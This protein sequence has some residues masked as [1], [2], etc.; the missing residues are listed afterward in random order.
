MKVG[1]AVRVVRSIGT[2]YLKGRC[3]EITE[4]QD[5]CHVW[6][7]LV[8]TRGEFSFCFDEVEVVNESR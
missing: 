1:D 8:G 6:V 3:G 5:S 7:R 4:V 2:G